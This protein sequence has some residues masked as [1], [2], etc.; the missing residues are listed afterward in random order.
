MKTSKAFTTILILIVLASILPSSCTPQPTASPTAAPTRVPPPTETVIPAPTQT[1][2]VPPIPLPKLTLKPGDLYFNLDGKPAFLFSRNPAGWTPGDWAALAE[3]AHQQGDQFVRVFTTSASMGGDHGYGYTV[4]GEILDGWS[5]NWEHF[6]DVADADGLYVVPS[7]WGWIN[8]S[9]TGNNN[10]A[11]N[12]FNSANGGPAKDPRDIFKKDSPTQLLYLKWFKQLVTRWQAHKN[13]LAWEVVTEV[14]L[15]PGI[16]QPEGIYLA[17]QLAQ[18]VREADSLHRPVTASVADWSGWSELLRS[19]AVDYI[20]FHPYPPAGD[21]DR[22]IL[23]QVPLLLKTYHKPV[24]IGESGVV[25]ATP[26]ANGNITIPPNV[27]TGFQHA[28]WAELVSGAMNGR[29]LWWEDGYG[30]YIPSMEMPYVQKYTDVEA[31]VVQFA[32]GVDMTGFKPITA[33]ASGKIFGAALGNETMIIGWYRDA[34]CEPPNWNLQPVI[35]KQTVTLTVPGSAA[36]WRVDFY[37]T[38]TGTT[39]LTSA[40]VT[41]KGNTLTIPLPDFKDDIAFKLYTK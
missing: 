20:N 11:D 37:D 34:S 9:D 6:F 32:E 10:W 38:R 27:R 22:R 13:I 23:E 14:N 24:L 35:S 3:M 19:D 8:W 36:N 21:L 40:F 15:I 4:T 26:D 31:P 25:S 16:S 17:R 2:T 12:P 41:L 39:I 7:F 30:I 5:D 1:A 29:A 18:V 33:R 28:I